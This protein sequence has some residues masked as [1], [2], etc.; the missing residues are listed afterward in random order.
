MKE[1]KRIAMVGLGYIGLPTAA[2]MASRGLDVIGIDVNQDAVDTINQ[3]EIH[4]VEPDLDIV[5]RSAVNTGKL[6]ATT[7]AEAA[8]AFLIAVP[9]PFEDG[10]KPDLSYIESAAR[11]IAP[12]LEAGNLVVLESTSPVG[13]TEKLAAWIAEQRPDLSF[14]QQQKE[15]AD[16]QIAHCPER[17]LPGYVLQ[18]LVSNDRIIGGMTP[19]CA[20]AATRLY[21]NFVKGDC[22]ATTARTAELSKLTENAFR[23]VNIAFANELSLVCDKLGVNVWEL[24]ELANRHPRVS[25]LQPGPGVGGHCIAVDPWFIVD[26]A[27]EESRLIRTAREVNDS[28]PRYV[29]D[30]VRRRAERFKEP[31]IACFGLAFKANIDDLRESPAI[32]IALELAKEH[33]GNLLLVE[34]NINKLPDAFA[35]N[36][37]VSLVGIEAAL[38]QADIL[39][40]LVDHDEFKMLNA[41]A[42]KE[43]IVIDVRGMWRG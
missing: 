33:L 17:V 21:K 24:I 37:K 16:V 11:L 26:S 36:E 35:K 34:P 14:P 12:V 28:K 8:D 31:T 18:E 40:G 5:V 19:H 9:T 23:D 25:I 27:P 32:D 30:R 4:I 10:H 39:V 29:I 41:D 3:G 13:T 38:D 2:I 15:H 7:E 22:L 1:F 6:R 20:E 43:K 42:L